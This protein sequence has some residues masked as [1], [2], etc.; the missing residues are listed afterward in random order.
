MTR[1]RPKRDRNLTGLLGEGLAD[2][3]KSRPAGESA[4]TL[5]VTALQPGA[6][7]P[8]RTFDDATLASLAES[9]R[10]EGVL[11]PLLVRP[12]EGGHEIVA[13]ERRW[14][15][16]QI[17]GL[18][19]VPVV[20]RE[21]DDRQASVAALLENLQRE[22]LNVIDEVEGKLRLVAL[23]LGVDDERARQHLHQ[24]LGRKA[25]AEAEQTRMAE[26][27]APLGETWAGFTKNKLRILR[28]PPILLD[29]LRDGMPLTLAAVI[30]GAPEAHHAELIALAQGGATR[31]ELRAAAE[32]LK[33]P[34]RPAGESRAVLASRHLSS[35]R[36]MARLSDEDRAAVDQ[37]LEQMPKA[38]LAEG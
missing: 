21:M 33:T 14:R 3:Q 20:I 24:L 7:Q 37:W 22:D 15:A 28:W 12:V 30:A 4:A 19:E 16:A 36:F 17:A 13:G 29:A 11:Q 31:A 10:A 26:L 8:R 18:T 6:H 1:P 38:L 5:P 9:I 32:R 35:R 25:G 23:T 34:V 27:F 2:L